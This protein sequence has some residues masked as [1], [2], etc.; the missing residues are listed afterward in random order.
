MDHWPEAVLPKVCAGLGSSKALGPGRCPMGSWWS[1]VERSV[2][3]SYLVA[4]RLEAL[5]IVAWRPHIWN[6]GVWRP[7]RVGLLQSLQEAR[8]APWARSEGRC[9]L[10][11]P[12]APGRTGREARTWRENCCRCPQ[13]PG[14]D[15]T[16]RGVGMWAGVEQ[17]EGWGVAP[18]SDHFSLTLDLVKCEQKWSL[19]QVIL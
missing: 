6:L 17:G 1:Q 3:T 4:W 15:W 7:D 11:G 13:P 16:R 8:Q 18:R 12:P 2:G 9:A 19:R 10:G 5:K 14:G